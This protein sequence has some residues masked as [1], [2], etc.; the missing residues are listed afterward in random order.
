M[1]FLVV[2][3]TKH[4]YTEGVLAVFFTDLFPNDWLATETESV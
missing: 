4:F 1:T 3:N 2:F